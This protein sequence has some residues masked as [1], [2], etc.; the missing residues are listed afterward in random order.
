MVKKKAA[1]KKT[2]KK[3]A[4]KK[5]A[6]AKRI[7]AIKE[8]MTKTALYASIAETTELSKKDV[9]KVFDALADVINGHIKKNAAGTFTLPGLL[10]VKTVRKPATKK[11]KGIN[12]FTGEETIFKAKPARTVVKI[13]P[14]K[15]MK[16]MTG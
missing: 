13:L 6:P 16:D 2:A 10:K 3:K 8:P 5:A 1:K 12:P 11:R 14:L 4:A 9:A 7:T 15:K